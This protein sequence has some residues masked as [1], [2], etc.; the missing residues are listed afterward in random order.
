MELSRRRNSLLNTFD[1]IATIKR[2]AKGIGLCIDPVVGQD[3]VIIRPIPRAMLSKV[4]EGEIWEGRLG[5]MHDKG[6]RNKY[7]KKILLQFFIPVKKRTLQ[8]AVSKN[9]VL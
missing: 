6:A 7:G 2:D 8:Y 1:I 9:P 5:I 4:N 3:T